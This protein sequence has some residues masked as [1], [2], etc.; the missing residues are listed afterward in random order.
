MRRHLALVLTSVATGIV[1]ISAQQ[2]PARPP[3]TDQEIG[4][5]AQLVM[6][7]DTRNFD[8]AVL[9]SLLRSTHP[10]VRRRA[11]VA[12][13]RIIGQPPAQQPPLPPKGS[14]LL[15]GVRSERDPEILATVAWATGQLRDPANVPWL[16]HLLSD[17]QTPAV[18]AKEAAGALG[19]IQSPDARTALANYLSSAPATATAADVVGEAL[20]AIGRRGRDDLGPVLRWTTSTNVEVRWRATWALFRLRDPSAFSALLK[21]ADDPSGDVRYWA[22]RGLGPIPP[23]GQRGRAAEPPPPA[24]PAPDPALVEK[25]SARLRAAL[26]DPDRRVRTEALRALGGYDDDASFEAVVGMLDSPDTWVSVTAAEVLATKASRADVV[27]PRLV[28]AT[29]PTKPLALRH[30]ALA[31]L[32]TM[33]PERALPSAEALVRSKSVAVRAAAAQALSSR[34]G[35]A[36]K[37][38]LAAIAAEP[39]MKDLLPAQGGGPQAPRPT[40][41]ARTHGDYRKIVERWVVPDYKGAPKPRSIWTFAR[42]QI[43]IELFPGDAPLATD[44]FVSLV[45][46]GAIVGTEFGRLVPNFVAQQRT[47][48][49]TFTQRDEV[50]R[51]G[52]TRANLSWASAGLDTGRPGYTL[53]HTPQPHNEGN[54]TSLGRVVRGMDVV[55]RLELGDA[56][57]ATRMIRK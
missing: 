57:T 25:L 33:A 30:T 37:A 13:G 48:T 51:R 14:A 2:R 22:V 45:E 20:L 24:D 35:E 29:A 38:K 21:L 11:I 36:G 39:G 31:P 42:G 50:N 43:E 40:A 41:P 46:S 12:V 34:L 18:A 7:E 10:E 9:S 17:S 3:L 56:V 26:K 52:L 47:I 44:Y 6:L 8:E 32:V 53:G 49:G 27:V 23:P 5:I 15:A 55:D 16:A 1:A 54:F 4:A 19:K 28:A